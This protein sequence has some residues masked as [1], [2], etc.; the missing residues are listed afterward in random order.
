M[1][2][3]FFMPMIPPTITQQEHQVKV[4]NGKPFFYDPQE[5]KNARAKLEAH[6]ACF[7]PEKKYDTAVMLVVKWLFPKGKQH[8]NGEYRTTRPDTDNLQKLLK[9]CMT[10]LGFWKDDCLVVSE[11]VEKFWANIP[12]IYILIQEV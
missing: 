3:E 7:V 9:D 12:G 5:L 11:H 1:K 4:I 10:H 6:L 2:T 8:K